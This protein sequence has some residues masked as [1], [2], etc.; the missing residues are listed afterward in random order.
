[1][2]GGIVITSNQQMGPR[3]SFTTH[4]RSTNSKN[5]KEIR[6]TDNGVYHST[7]KTTET[8]T[9]TARTKDCDDSDGMRKIT[10]VKIS[11]Q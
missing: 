4:H 7:T 10:L 9:S 6:K 11:G 1:M 8:Y 3:E 2:C 5:K